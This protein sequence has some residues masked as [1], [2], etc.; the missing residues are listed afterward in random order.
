MS[1]QQ[2]Y[3]YQY[4]YLDS[5]SFN[6]VENNNLY[7]D[8]RGA[9]ATNII[10]SSSC[11]SHS[12]FTLKSPV[13]ILRVKMDGQSLSGYGGLATENLVDIQGD[14]YHEIKDI[15]IYGGYNGIYISSS[16]NPELYMLDF[17]IA[18]ATGSAIRVEGGEVETRIGFF[19]DNNIS[20][21]LVTGSVYFST[22]G[23]EFYVNNGQIGILYN[24]QSCDVERISV[25]SNEFSGDGIYFTGSFFS[26]H[27]DTEIKIGGNTNL[28]NNNPF[29]YLSFW[30]NIVAMSTNPA[31]EFRKASGS[32]FAS[33][34]AKKFKVENNRFTYLSEVTKSMLITSTGNLQASSVNQSVAVSIVKNSDSASFM[35]APVE[36][37]YTNAN[38]PF[39]FALQGIVE[40][41][42]DDFVELW[43]TNQSSNTNT[44]LVQDMQFVI[45][46]L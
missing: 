10:P 17:E 31:G 44:V 8:E 20:V 7:D 18:H 26:E 30:N 4:A 35:Y 6:A 16:Y 13:D 25:I 43:Y 9:A 12:L 36:I 29:G 32:N 33:T 14:N 46:E 34:P 1:A 23:S 24:S 19:K 21:N 41:K 11:Y 15:F 40:M 2:K 37:R 28:S 22:I 38:Q 39:N 3:L 45:R 42:Q 27:H 5:S